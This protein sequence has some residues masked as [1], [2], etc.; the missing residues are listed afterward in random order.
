MGA[1][2]F[3]HTSRGKTVDEAFNNAVESA[4][5]DHGHS[6]YTG[7][8][9]EKP[10]FVEFPEI[11]LDRANELLGLTTMP[12]LILLVDEDA[13]SALTERERHFIETHDDK[14]GDACA[15]PIEDGTWMFMG[16][17]SS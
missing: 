16:W 17:A 1:E 6:G 8:I 2:Q 13:L 3:E 11:T 4:G 5:W 14:W 12:G 10:G 15:I 9:A 7:T